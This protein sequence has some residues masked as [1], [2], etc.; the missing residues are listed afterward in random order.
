MAEVK[1]VRAKKMRQIQALLD[2]ASNT[3]FEAEADSA[4]AKA[5]Q[6][7]TEF[8]IEQWELD[9]LKPRNQREE[10]ENRFIDVCSNDHTALASFM[11]LVSA[12]GTHCRCRMLHYSYGVKGT[13]YRVRLWGFPSDLDYAEMLWTGLLLQLT[14][15]MSP[16]YDS[17]QSYEQNLVRLKES[18]MKW[19]DAHRI[20]QPNTPWE[21]RHG[22]KYTGIYTKFCK[23][24][25]RERIY[26][27]PT[28]FVRSFCD[29]FAMRVDERL[30][31]LREKR[32]EYAPGP[33][34]DIVLRDRAKEVDD[35]FNDVPKAKGGI[36]VHNGKTDVAAIK[37]GVAAGDRADLSQTRLQRKKELG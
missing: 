30:W 4:R 23:E 22:V 13:T 10:V 36:K 18:G 28:V 3:P 7:M 9:Q 27:S 8:I 29:G 21:R 2:R 5:D 25:N 37:H 32:K 12:V 1:E 11:R 17:D 26:T 6:L 16:K 19:E 15:E 35:I 24:H 31:E 20:L 33:G 34:T 14:K